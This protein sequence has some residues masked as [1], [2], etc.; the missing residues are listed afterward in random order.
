MEKL[1]I[2]FALLALSAIVIPFA[3]S[4]YRNKIV[5]ELINVQ[6]GLKDH[7]EVVDF[8]SDADGYGTLNATKVIITNH[9]FRELANVTLT[10][11]NSNKP[12]RVRL[13]DPTTLARDDVSI[14]IADKNIRIA[15]DTLPRNERLEIQYCTIG[16]IEWQ[17]KMLKGAGSKFEIV[18]NQKYL[19]RKNGVSFWWLMACLVVSLISHVMQV[20]GR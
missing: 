13:S 3:V 19:D 14:T 11:P 4:R 5:F 16:T 17:S 8:T 7:N 1:V 2:P 6:I 9:G 18:K 10:L 12:M 15:V 20:I